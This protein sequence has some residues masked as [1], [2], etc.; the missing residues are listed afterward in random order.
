M[1]EYFFIGYRWTTAQAYLIP[2]RPNLHVSTGSHVERI[3][4]DARNRAI[5]VKFR[6]AETG[7]VKNVYA[8]KEV[9]LSAGTVGSPHLL[10]LSG[11][12]PPEHLAKV[13]VGFTLH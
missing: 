1:H 10:L 8:T 13:G 9:I 12:G 11:I 4:L 5:G 6:N 3:L 2:S 7:R